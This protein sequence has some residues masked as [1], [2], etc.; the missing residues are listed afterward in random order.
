MLDLMTGIGFN[1]YEHVPPSNVRDL[2]RLGDFTVYGFKIQKVTS[3][4]CRSESHEEIKERKLMI[5]GLQGELNKEFKAYKLLKKRLDEA[6][7]RIELGLSDYYES[8]SKIKDS[9]EKD[10]QKRGEVLKIMSSLES[11]KAT[12]E[13]QYGQ[14]LEI[15]DKRIKDLKREL[16]VQRTVLYS[17]E[18]CLFVISDNYA[19]QVTFKQLQDKLIFMK[20]VK[21]IS[22]TYQQDLERGSL[23]KLSLLLSRVFVPAHEKYDKGK[24]DRY[25]K[26]IDEDLPFGIAYSAISFFLRSSTS[27]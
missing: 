5:E 20:D 17:V 6:C 10:E 3:F 22:D 24:A 4:N 15:I 7:K 25:A 18:N 8:L 9:E 14:Q 12:L 13:N 27:S 26:I 21:F 23:R 19:S 11:D 16:S 2:V 1:N